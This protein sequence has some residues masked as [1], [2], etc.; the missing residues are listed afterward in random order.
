MLARSI[1]GQQASRRLV[2]RV[3]K[4]ASGFSTSIARPAGVLPASHD[5]VGPPIYLFLR[6]Y[7]VGF[8]LIMFVALESKFDRGRPGG[9]QD[10]HKCEPSTTCLRPAVS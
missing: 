2:G 9:L 1:F 10:S 5:K 7:Q 6:I 4:N 8:G 3:T